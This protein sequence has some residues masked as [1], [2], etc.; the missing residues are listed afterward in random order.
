MVRCGGSTLS[1]TQLYPLVCVTRRHP[2]ASALRCTHNVTRRAY[3][4]QWG[5]VKID[6]CGVFYAAGVTGNH[7]VYASANE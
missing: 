6:P 1:V 7:T 3:L 5:G 4:M 2:L